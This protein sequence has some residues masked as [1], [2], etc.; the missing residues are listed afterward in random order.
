MKELFKKLLTGLLCLT[1]LFVA[2]GCGGNPDTNGDDNSGDGGVSSGTQITLKIESAAPIRYNYKSL[3]TSEEEGTQLYNQ[4][5]FTKKLV[6]GFKELYPNIKLTFQEDGW[7]DALYQT[8]Q[9]YIRDYAAGGS[10]PVDIMIGE[11]Y[12][13][14]FAENGVF[15]E[16]DASKF[17]NVVSGAV[18][19][20]TIDNKLYAVPMCTGIMGL[21]Y[22]TTILQ[23]VGI[24]ENEWAPKTWAELVANCKK[25]SDYAKA[26]N[27]SYSGIIMNNVSGMPSAYRAAAIMRQAGGDFLDAN[28]NLAVNSAANQEAYAYLRS[29]AQYAYPDSLTATSEDTCQYYFINKGYAAYMYEGQW[30]MSNAGDHIKST[31]LP[32]KNADGTGT[33][34]IYIGN[35]LF[36]I[37]NGS[38]NKEAAQLFLEYLTSKEVQ[39]WFYELD[40]RLPINTETLRSEEI[41]TIHPNI[42]SYIDEL[43][44]G[45]F[46]GGLVSF[47]KNSS[48][49]WEKWGTFHKD[50]LTGTASISTLADNL[51][52][53]ISQ[54]L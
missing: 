45:G 1:M 8:Q 10:M 38:K 24:P 17:T 25:V 33:G 50:V 40:G 5:L 21:Q 47:T 16:L 29:L 54:W 52:T 15:A 6:E 39:L 23:E 48:N 30:S 51:Q 3:L 22:N 13:G 19:D 9:L 37:T 36:G 18:A 4:A 44:A 43:L 27:K 7:G 35:V 41:R 28:G 20:V 49:I 53:S 14:F 2:V 46:N 12:M 11:T 31:T 34:N 32:T 26:N 42:N